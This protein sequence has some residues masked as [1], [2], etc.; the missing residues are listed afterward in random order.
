MTQPQWNPQLNEPVAKKNSKNTW[1]TCGIITL[2]VICVG[3]FLLFGGFGILMAIF[4]AEPEGL[5][6]EIIAPPTVKTG[7]DFVVGVHLGNTGNKT[8]NVTEIQLP[9][10]LLEGAVFIKSQPASTGQMSYSGY[11]GYKFDL[12]LGPGTEQTV[13]FSFR[14]VSGVEYSGEV[15]AIVGTKRKSSNLRV[16]VTGQP[17]VPQAQTNQTPEPQPGNI[18]FQSVVQIIAMVNLN[19][20]IQPGW[21]GS[22][23]IISPD[24]FILTNAHV[25]LSDPY[26]EVNSLIVSITTSQDQPPVPMYSAEVLQADAALDLAVIRIIGDANGNPIDSS[27]LNLPMIPVGDSDNLQLGDSLVILGYPGIGGETIT[28]TRGEVS[29][30]T[31]D[32]VYGNRGFIKTSA[33]IAGGNSGGM[34]TNSNNELIGVPTQV[35]YGGEGEIVDCRALADTNGDGITDNRDSCIP[36]GGFIN[37]LRPVKL[38]VPLIEAAR[39]GEIMIHQGAEGQAQEAPS[40]TLIVED[41]FS[42]D[43]GYWGIGGSDDGNVS[44]QDGELWFEVLSTNFYYWSDYEYS[45]DLSDTIFSVDARVQQATGVGDFGFLCRIQDSDNFYSLEVSEDGYFSIWKLQDGKTT[46]L[47]EWEYSNEIPIGQPM[48]VVAACVGDKLALGVND[49]ILVEISDNTFRKGRIGLLT[50][51]FESP[52][53]IVAFDNFRVHRP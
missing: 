32:R 8:L 18:P 20:Q 38:A 39:N 17:A 29:G 10:S 28:L 2:V 34:A 31:A 9:Q 30:F 47:H 45:Q 50:G 36:T 19:G 4:G 21:T 25:V 16:V 7:E 51:T 13:E 49:K 33:T 14:A 43:D 53:I 12:P 35:G 11:T 41:D 37:A 22:G 15:E 52:N 1:I 44:F 27:T 24:G 23:S 26:Y 40:G 3:S 6:I 46:Y 48:T 42:S 5:T